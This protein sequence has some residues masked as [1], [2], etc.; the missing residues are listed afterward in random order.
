MKAAPLIFALIMLAGWSTPSLAGDWYVHQTSHQMSVAPGYCYC[1][2]IAKASVLPGTVSYPMDMQVTE[3]Q[4]RNRLAAY[5]ARPDTC[6]NNCGFGAASSGGGGGPAGGPPR[7]RPAPSPECQE[8][9]KVGGCAGF[10]RGMIAGHE[11]AAGVS[12]AQCT[13][14]CLGKYH[15][16]Q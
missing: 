2:R 3:Q 5:A 6:P 15:C 11:S 8:L 14:N 16:A 12:I 4:A 1:Y 9:A 13:Q 10:C 7:P